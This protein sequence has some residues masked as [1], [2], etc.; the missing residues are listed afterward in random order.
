MT[1]TL[2]FKHLNLFKIF[3]VHFDAFGVG[4]SGVLSQGHFMAPFSEKLNEAKRKYSIYER[5][6]YAIVQELRH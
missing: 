3:E 2:I 4:I 6:L 5:E 1:K